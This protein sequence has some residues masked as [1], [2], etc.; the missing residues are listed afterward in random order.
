L[1]ASKSRRERTG[2][3]PPLCFGALREPDTQSVCHNNVV[4]SM[5][6]RKIFNV[7]RPSTGRNPASDRFHRT[8]PHSRNP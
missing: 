6:Y 7:A 5:Y 4:T 8:A 2:L 3:V 1:S